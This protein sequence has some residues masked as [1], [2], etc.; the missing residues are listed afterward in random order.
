MGMV[1]FRMTLALVLVAGGAMCSGKPGMPPPHSFVEP[2]LVHAAFAR[3]GKAP[4]LAACPAKF[5][6]SLETNGI[7]PEGTA[8]GV[9][10]PKPLHIPEAEFSE[11]A[12]RD[13]N[14]KQ[15]RPF[16]SISAIAMIV[17]PHGNPQDLCV[18]RSA[19]YDLDD[20]AAKVVSQYRFEP[21]MKDGQPV[22]M[23]LKVE[24]RFSMR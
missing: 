15:L 6:D 2:Q 12:R 5:D 24:I 23:R 16:E 11:K 10:L 18:V 19:A 22:K 13:I 8:G 3:E 7:A 14:K 21:A 1:N 9:T 20:Q 4:R 17:D